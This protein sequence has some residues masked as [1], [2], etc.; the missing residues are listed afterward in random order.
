MNAGRLLRETGYDTDELRG[1]IAPVDPNQVNVWPAS[2]VTR[3][4]WG[5]GIRGVTLWRWVLVDPDMI[6]G[7]RDRLARL[8]IHELV[9]VRQ[10]AE[11]GYLRFMARYLSDYVGSRLDG[12]SHHEAYLAISAER[13]AREVTARVGRR[14]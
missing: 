12:M 13:E 6:R 7:E 4:F 2:S 8:V 10:F 1:A 3:R 5:P 14:T 11:L 9:H